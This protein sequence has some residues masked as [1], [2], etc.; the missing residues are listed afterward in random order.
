MGTQFCGERFFFVVVV[1]LFRFGFVFLR[2]G[3]SV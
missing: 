1:V 3:F 2:K